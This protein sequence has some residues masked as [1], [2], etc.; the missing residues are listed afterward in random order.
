MA[1]PR[2]QTGWIFKRGTKNPVW[3]GR[4]REDAL[5]EDGSRIRR[6][7]SV[8]LGPVREITKRQAQRLLSERLA[9]I[10]QGRHKPEFMIPF[11][12]FVLE[13]W[14]PNIYPTLR[15]STVKNYRYLIRRH[16]LPFFGQLCLPQIGPLDV[17]M[18]LSEKAKHISG[19]TVLSLRNL[20]SKIFGTAKRWEFIPSNPASGA[21][22]PSLADTKE[23]VTLTP[24][25]V[26]A[27]L[28]EL[29]EPYRT[30]VLLAVLSGLRRGEIFGLRWKYVDFGDGSIT[31]A[32]SNYEGRQAPPKTRASRRKVYVD[33]AALDA[34]A[35]LHPALSQPDDF[36]F[37][38]ERGTPMS[39]HNV[40]RRE[41][42]PACERAGIPVVGWHNFRYTYATWAD[43]SR[44]SIKALQSQ[45][46]H[47]DSRLT[48]SVYTQPI[49]DAQRGLASKIARVLL[50][51]APKLE[52][53][54][55]GSKVLIQ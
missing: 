44:E 9:D 3:V 31:V 12:R 55:E 53:G 24:Q 54:K 21:Q 47:T 22:V 17:Q 29:E 32:E 14:E 4:F 23:R 39:P 51:N 36:V 46:G 15:Y 7:R 19:K 49:P 18:F 48:L 10:N 38:T 41:L 37:H 28:A 50:P 45:L 25:Q 16:L 26:R 40:S 1:R 20:L 35:R 42:R 30:M 27:L 2:W 5:A 11:E 34:L 13:R 6:E 52:Q 33:S 8:I 43:P